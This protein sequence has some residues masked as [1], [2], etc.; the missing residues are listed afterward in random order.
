M[1]SRYK[2]K[3]KCITCLCLLTVLREYRRSEIIVFYVHEGAEMPLPPL[4][5]L[6]ALRVLLSPCRTNGSKQCT[7]SY[8]PH[9]CRS[10]STAKHKHAHTYPFVV[11]RPAA[12]KN[13][14]FQRSK[15]RGVPPPS[16]S[17]RPAT[18]TAATAAKAWTVLAEPSRQDRDEK[19]DAAAAAAEVKGRPNS[20]DGGPGKPKKAGS[21]S[22]SGSLPEALKSA[23]ASA[24]SGDGGRN[25]GNGA[26]SGGAAAVDPENLEC[27]LV[28]HSVQ[29]GL[30]GGDAVLAS[31]R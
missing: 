31:V 7:D 11:V 19:E 26:G 5:P 13:T 9:S 12:G 22:G 30:G 3:Q 6:S 1:L 14:F 20:H 17:A 29:A 16:S 24:P 23:A 4:S 18:A 28:F 27:L 2:K 15:R 8:I 10:G 25:R 21:A